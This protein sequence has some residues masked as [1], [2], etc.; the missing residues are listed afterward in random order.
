MITRK[1]RLIIIGSIILIALLLL[2]WILLTLRKPAVTEPVVVLQPTEE[3]VEKQKIN[4]QDK[5]IDIQSDSDTQKRQKTASINSLSKTFVERYGSYSNEAKFQNLKDVILM[6]APEF[7]ANTQNIIDTGKSPNEYYGITTRVIT[8]NVEELDE[9]A[10]TAIVVL[11]TQREE[12][13]VSV[14]NT[15]VWYQKIRVEFVKL[16]GVWKVVSASWL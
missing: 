5:N 6:M 9:T 8:V 14:S 11:N 16:S 2:L 15:S 3:V 13:K 12:S 4:V 10:G 7:A 1:Q